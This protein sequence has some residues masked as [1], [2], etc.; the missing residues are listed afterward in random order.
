MSRTVFQYAFR[1]CGLALA[2]LLPARLARAEGP[3]IYF[4]GVQRDCERDLKLD[5]AVERRLMKKGTTVALVRQP[6]G[7]PLPPCFGERCGQLF[8]KSCPATTG[9]LLGAQVAYGK[10][11]LKFRL[12]LHDLATGQTAYQD[13]YCQSCEMVGTLA[14]Q[15]ARLLASPH[16]G[17]APEPMPQYCA[18][19]PSQATVQPSGPLFLTVY[20]DGK[21]KAVLLAALKQQLDLLGRKVLPVPVESKTYLLDVLQ[22]IVAGQANAQVLGAELQKEGKVQ[23]FLYDQK[24]ALS[25]NK[26]VEC[27]ECDKDKDV[28]VARVQPEVSA[29]LDYCFSETCGSGHAAAPAAACEP[30]PDPVCAAGTAA[31]L[32]SAPPAGRYIDPSTAKIVKGSVWSLFAA[33]AATTVALL[34]ANQASSEQING[35]PYESSLSRPFWFGLGVSALTLAVAIPTTI[36]VNHASHGVTGVASVDTAQAIQCPN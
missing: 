5:H 9:R 10:D 8:K 36:V 6:T 23:M 3:A 30:F 17:A 11:V 34:I 29:I 1:L 14:T 26:T 32:T 12:W 4:V 7:A 15:A 16:F 13:D 20:G 18:Q 21:H 25:A 19:L 31:S 2:L 24:T 22:K 35:R 28:L 33:S 27:G